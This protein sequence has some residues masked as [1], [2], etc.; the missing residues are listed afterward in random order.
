[1]NYEICSHYYSQ[2]VKF[3]LRRLISSLLNT[4]YLLLWHL[5]K[6]KSI[7]QQLI[8]FFFNLKLSAHTI[9]DHF[10]SLWNGKCDYY[11][12]IFCERIVDLRQKRYL[13]KTKI[14]EG[15]IRQLNIFY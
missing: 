1:M 13:N 3:P 4:I 5:F 7:I 8:F 15:Q 6:N 12:K 14:F 11:K 2:V 10:Y 9:D